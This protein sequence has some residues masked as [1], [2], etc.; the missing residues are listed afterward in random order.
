M[1]ENACAGGE[2]LKALFSSGAEHVT[3]EGLRTDIGQRAVGGT[4]APSAMEVNVS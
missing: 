1:V 3:R 4:F 2:N